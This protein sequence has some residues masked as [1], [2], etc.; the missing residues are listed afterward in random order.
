[1]LEVEPHPVAERDGADLIEVATAFGDAADLKAPFMHG[2]S[3]EVAVLATEAAKRGGLDTMTTERL[4]ISALLHDLGRVGV[5]DIVWE[6]PGPLTTAEWE[7]VRMHPY[8][9]ER[10]LAISRTL[11]P[12]ARVAGMHHERLDGSGYFRGSKRSEIPMPARILAAAVAFVAMTQ[13]RPYRP[14]MEPEQASQ[15]LTADAKSR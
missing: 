2:H 3:R 1:M 11:E 12:M 6:K 9:S 15:Q 13:N 7:L 14:A 10:I 4:G 5:S 8:H